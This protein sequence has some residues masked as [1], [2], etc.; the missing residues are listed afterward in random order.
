[1]DRVHVF[2]S[3]PPGKY[4]FS[5][6]QTGANFPTGTSFSFQYWKTV[7]LQAGDPLIGDNPTRII[8]ELGRVG[9]CVSNA[10]IQVDVWT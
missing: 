4:G 7:N 2:T 5:L 9:W 3:T 10:R 8:E 1:M 6:D